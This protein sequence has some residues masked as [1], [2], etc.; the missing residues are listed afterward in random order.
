VS[1]YIRLYI[2]G[3][4]AYTFCVENFK[5]VEKNT[6]FLIVKKKSIKSCIT[7]Q[8]MVSTLK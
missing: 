1:S 3:G 2:N 4:Y 7:H 6:N 5:A 8:S